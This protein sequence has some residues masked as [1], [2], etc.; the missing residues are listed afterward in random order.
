MTCFDF[1]GT[2]IRPQVYR[3][4]DAGDATFKYLVIVSRDL[5]RTEITALPSRQ[6]LSQR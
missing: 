3:C 5:R 1:E 4:C 6:L 2:I